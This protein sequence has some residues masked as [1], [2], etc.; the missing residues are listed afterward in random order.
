[1]GEKM[2]NW[3]QKLVDQHD[4][5]LDKKKL[6]QKQRNILESAIQ[7]FAEKGYNGTTT[8]EIAKLAGVAEATIFKHYRSKKGLLLRLVIPA[9]AKFASPFILNPLVQILEQDKP[10]EVILEELIQDRVTL[11]ENN[12]KTIRIVI[13]ESLFHSDLREALQEMVANRVIANVEQKVNRLKEQGKLRRD[14]PNRI[15][16]RGIISQVFGF[17][18]AKNVLSESLSAGGEL[19][20]LKWTVEMMLHGIKGEPE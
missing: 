7:L 12:W 20:E 2:D 3:I 17:L 6:T 8:N 15:L 4:I 16:L 14:L 11:V 18:I 9:I 1:V 19:E 5:N 10:I 13:V